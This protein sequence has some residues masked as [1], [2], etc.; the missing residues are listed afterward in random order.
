MYQLKNELDAGSIKPFY[1][2]YG[3][4][5]Y[6]I[7]EY[8]NRLL[9]ALV[10]NGDTMNFTAFS[11]EKL[12]VPSLLDLARTIPFLSEHRVIIVEESGFFIKA[13]EALEEGLKDIADTTVLIFV[14]PDQEKSTGTVKGVDKR[15]R[16]YKYFDKAEAA[17]CF[18]VP[19]DA[20]LINWIGTRL[21]ASGLP[22]EKRVP[23]RLLDAAGRDMQ[24]LENE[25]EKLISYT[26]GRD[27]ILVKDVDEIC[28]SEVEDKVFEMIDA[29]SS[30]DKKRSLQLYSDLLYLKEPPMKIIALIRRQYLILL[31]LKH[32]KND[33]TPRS[34]YAKLAGI[35]PFLLKRYET[36][37]ESRNY[38]Q[39]LRYADACFE[40]SIK[41]QQGILSD[42]NSLEQLVLL[43]LSETE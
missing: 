20:T 37:A 11:G 21:S 9:S 30:R 34:E 27:R 14:E 12:D 33:G 43:L 22:I 42:R 6:L 32:M 31:K 29:L 40:A 41:V 10:P 15:G 38:E 1:L 24:A 3:S 28:I 7:R 39:L 23:E 35:A 8:K 2:L 5:R 19:D 36:Q 13:P 25:I 26:M 18:D 4:E 16:L 17:Y